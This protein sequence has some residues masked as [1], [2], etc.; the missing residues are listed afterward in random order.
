MR[1]FYGFLVCSMF[2]SMLFG[3]VLNRSAIGC[4][5]GMTGDM[6]GLCVPVTDGMI[7]IDGGLDPDAFMVDAGPDTGFDA[8]LPDG[9][10]PDAF[11]EPDTGP[12][13]GGFPDANRPDT[14]MMDGGRPEIELR[15]QHVSGGRSVGIAYRVLSGTT[16]LIPWNFDGCYGA[17]G[18]EI[19]P[20]EGCLVADPVLMSGRTVEMFAY[21]GSDGMGATCTIATCASRS[22]CLPDSCP[23]TYTFQFMISPAAS[24]TVTINALDTNGDTIGD[25]ATVSYVLP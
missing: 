15:I 1:T 7:M 14:G 16:P 6:T 4:D 13:D 5:P 24:G 17:T 20:G 10:S 25:S 2:G 12:P 19:P 22:L 21:D 3:C 18:M 8:D 11:R 23:G 9:W